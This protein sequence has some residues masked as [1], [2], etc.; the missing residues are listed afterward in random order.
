MKKRIVG[1]LSMILCVVLMVVM[2][3]V[4]VLAQEHERPAAIK[5]DPVYHI[6]PEYADMIDVEDLYHPAQTD[7]QEDLQTDYINEADYMTIEEAAAVL[8]EQMKNRVY[9][10]TVLVKVPA[11]DT[12]TWYD[13]FDL[14]MAHT[15]NPKEGDYIFRQ[16]DGWTGDGYYYNID[17]YHYKHLTYFV[18]YKT[19]A[20]QEMAV[21]AEVKYLL[22]QLNVYQATDYEK[23]KAIYDWIC[24][25]V[26]YDYDNLENDDYELKYTAYAALFNRTAVCQGYAVLFYRL[27][28]ELGVDS[29]YIRG[30]S[31]GGN[32]GWNIVELDNEYY[33][34]DTTWDANNAVAGYA[35][36][37]FLKCMDDFPDHI[38]RDEYLTAEFHAEYPMGT[39]NYE[40]AI[41]TAA[42]GTFGS[43]LEWKLNGKGVLTISGNGNMPNYDAANWTPWY[44]YAANIKTLVIEAGVLNIGSNA[45][46][47]CWNLSSIIFNGAAP[48]ISDN[49]FAGVIATVK[50]P[51]LDPSWTA[52]KLVGYGGNLTWVTDE[53]KGDGWVKSGETWFYLQN[54]QKYIGWLNQNGIWYYLDSS[55]A[56]AVGW[57]QIAGKWFYFDTSGVMQTGWRL[58]DGTW[59]YLDDNGN[60]TVGWKQMGGT[61]YYFGSNGAMTVGW[62]SDAG[63]WYYFNKNGA[64]QTGWVQVDGHWYYLD[65][66]MKKDWQNIDGKWYYFD[67]T[68]GAMQTG[69]LRQN[70]KWY[71]LA[72]EMQTGWTQVD[73]AWYYMDG[74]GIMQ[75]GWQQL[76]GNWYY[77]GNDG[78]M[79]VG[80]ARDGGK[81]YHFADNGMMQTGWVQVG[82]HWYYLD[83]EMKTGWQN[84]G[85]QWYYFDTAGGAMQT[86]WQQISGNWYYFDNAMQTGWVQADGQWYYLEDTGIIHTGWLEQNGEW[87]YFNDH[88]VMQTGWAEING[89]WYYFDNTMQTGWAQ[90]GN[91]WYYL[92]S[93][94]VI[95]TGWQRIDGQWYYFDNAMQTGWQ[96]IGGNWYYFDNAMQTG[97]KQ[98]SREWYYFNADGIM[99]TGWLNLGNDWY[100]MDISG[101]MLTGTHTIDGKLYYFDP[102]GVWVP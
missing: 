13:I 42:S 93:N 30:F 79:S 65:Q 26:T 62:A 1:I 46:A 97:W 16:Y 10:T 89:K 17:G 52:E 73:G 60:M 23:V 48:K 11:E 39:M 12:N 88:G 75:T 50:Y 83:Q 59:Y 25:H 22:D 41:R 71:Y 78:K 58:V 94:G 37:Y 61:W 27:A 28:L 6:N 33:N 53:L 81:W 82:G 95:L 18:E 86:G 5:L 51:G 98:I 84:I 101:V 4:S 56:M 15:G 19:T 36:D 69:W 76:G 20:Q 54:G 45:F 63:K 67:V 74:N 14:A 99:H 77:L 35:Y 2:M 34:L 64:M 32:H 100:Y 85:G 38:R 90:D 47:S 80:W 3:P 31:N 44:S 66:D 24:Y 49:A 55:G 40:D 7:L 29:R 68:N 96:K 8:R 72:S 92:G 21:D 87:Y 57:M 91:D 70:G 43:G 102:N 9:E